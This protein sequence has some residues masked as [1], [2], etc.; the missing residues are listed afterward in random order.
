MAS[1]HEV[2]D[3]LKSALS[4]AEPVALQSALSTAEPVVRSY[5]LCGPISALQSAPLLHQLSPVPRRVAKLSFLHQ[6]FCN[7]YSAHKHAAK[8]AVIMLPKLLPLLHEPHPDIRKAAALT[9][10]A[11]AAAAAAASNQPMPGQPYQL[12]N[13]YQAD[14]VLIN[15][16]LQ[17]LSP[18]SGQPPPTA[19]V[20][21]TI[22][23][24]LFE[25]L[26]MLP[27][28]S[29]SLYASRTID[30]CQALLGSETT[31]PSALGPLLDIISVCLAAGRSSQPASTN[32]QAK[33]S[34]GCGAGAAG[35][36]LAAS[37]C[38]AAGRSTGNN[39]FA[40]S[41]FSDLVDLLL[42]WS[43]DPDVNG[44][45]RAKIS[46][47]LSSLQPYWRPHLPFASTLVRNIIEDL[48]ALVG[49]TQ[50]GPVAQPWTLTTPQAFARLLTALVDIL[51]GVLTSGL[52]ALQLFPV[53]PQLLSIFKH[54]LG[55]ETQPSSQARPSQP[56]S[57]NSQAKPSQG[58][59]AGA[60]GPSSAA[61]G[62][63]GVALLP[64]ICKCMCQ[65]LEALSV[66]VQSPDFA[67]TVATARM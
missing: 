31:P 66:G 38:Q 11:L 47:V 18:P 28:P 42:G 36:T 5:I 7:P 37:V 23:L 20:Q 54:A 67:L 55:G 4:T 8:G 24:A 64:V 25:C 62:E 52:G 59:A 21:E 17:T 39:R 41:E 40:I 58:C 34:Q 1:P 16:A 2:A 3:A 60:A 19:G 45:N 35:P 63:Q 46:S 14:N 22:L 30:V 56:A 49:D 10:G 50:A 6:V 15:Y 48:Q 9:A 65:L 12:H 26:R 61:K 32:S 43:Q 27:L 13:Q 29:A 57:A 51:G 53:Y 44:A 33:P